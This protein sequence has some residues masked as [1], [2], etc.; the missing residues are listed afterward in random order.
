LWESWVRSPW[1]FEDTASKHHELFHPMTQC[2]N[3][4]P[5]LGDSM[6]GALGRAPLLGNLKDEVFEVIWNALRAGLP[7]YRGPFGEPRGGYVCWGFWGKWIVYVS[8]FLSLKIVQVLNLSEALA[9]LRQIS[10]GCSFLDPEDNW[11]LSMGAIWNFAKG[12]GLL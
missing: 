12:T 1:S 10:L 9:S 6:E 4:H 3:V 8:T 11:K 7:L 2:H 5:P